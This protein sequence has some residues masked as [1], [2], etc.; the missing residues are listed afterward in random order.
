MVCLVTLGMKGAEGLGH[1]QV[2]RPQSLVT[3]GLLDHSWTEFIRYGVEYTQ[4]TR[5]GNIAYI[6]GAPSGLA[7]KHSIG[8][9]KQIHCS[10][11]LT[12]YICGSS[13]TNPSISVLETS[14]YHARFG[15]P[16]PQPG[17]FPGAWDGDLF[18]S[19]TT[20][21]GTR[22]LHTGWTISPGLN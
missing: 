12:Q 3:V 6:T 22:G 15:Y 14:T 7:A 5:P 9:A 16:G 17:C 11:P 20:I 21:Q 18:V 4:N 1:R 13:P 10:L 8:F 19:V 2:T